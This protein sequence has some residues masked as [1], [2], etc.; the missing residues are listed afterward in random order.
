MIS[1][2]VKRDSGHVNRFLNQLGLDRIKIKD[3]ESIVERQEQKGIAKYGHTIDDCPNDKYDWH[4]M[5]A[6]ELVDC[7]MYVRKLQQVEFFKGENL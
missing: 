1:D 3:W 4:Q 5:I 7:M 2:Q 6:E